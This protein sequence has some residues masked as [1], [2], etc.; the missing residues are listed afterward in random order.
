MLKRYVAAA[1]SLSLAAVLAACSRSASHEEQMEYL[2]RMAQHGVELH[3]TKGAG[4]FGD[5]EECYDS[6]QQLYAG[7]NGHDAPQVEDYAEKVALL[8]EG[9]RLFIESCVN[10]KPSPV[11]ARSGPAG[12]SA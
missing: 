7:P 3:A 4:F 1:L 5:Q 9:E 10:G 6:Y 8:K 2:R 11:S 12:S